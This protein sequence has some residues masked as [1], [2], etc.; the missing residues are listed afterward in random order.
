MITYRILL[1][2]YIVESEQLVISKSFRQIIKSLLL[3][4]DKLVTNPTRVN[5]N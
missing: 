4:S 3:P 1:K 2:Q 5:G